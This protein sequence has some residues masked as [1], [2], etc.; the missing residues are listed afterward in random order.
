VN[1]SAFTVT[2]D[3]TILLA[4]HVQPGARRPGVVGLHGDAVKLRVAAPPEAG[5]AN[6]EVC[7]VI[8]AALSARPRDVAV[9]SG[10]SARRKRLAIRSVPPDRVTAWLAGLPS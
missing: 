8:A 1:A 4:V 5:R 9:V 10:T 2:P 6:R 3:G 7:D